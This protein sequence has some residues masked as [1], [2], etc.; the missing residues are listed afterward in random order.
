VITLFPEMVLQGLGFGMPRVAMERGAMRLSARN[1]RDFSGNRHRSVDDRTYG[2]GP[3]MV[4]QAPPLAAALDAAKQAH[5][6]GLV[7]AM[8]PQGEK[9]SQ[10]WLERLA[11]EK[12]LFFICGRYEGIDERFIRDEVDLELSLGDFVLSGGELAAMAVIDGVAR[13]L[14]GVLGD[15]GSA[16][17]DSFSEGLLDHPHYTRPEVWRAQ[18]V[19]EVLLSGDHARIARWRLKQALGVTWTKRPDLLSDLALDTHRQQLLREWLAEQR[20]TGQDSGQ[21]PKE[22]DE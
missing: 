10:A 5:G 20:H 3:G 17:E 1:P 8:S 4:M 15:A 11:Q 16:R 6:P 2:G 19:P 18:A 12:T 9:L 22:D 13:L 14:P 21:D 7:I